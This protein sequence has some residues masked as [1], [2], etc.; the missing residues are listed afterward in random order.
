MYTIE[1]YLPFFIYFQE[2]RRFSVELEAVR[3][4]AEQEAKVYTE[5]FRREALAREEDLSVL[6]EQV[7]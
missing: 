3:N 6:K 7:R 4:A 2:R 5:Q 1:M